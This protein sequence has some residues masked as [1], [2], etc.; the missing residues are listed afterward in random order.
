[1]QSKYRFGVGILF[2][3]IKYSRPD[4]ANVVRELSKCINGA[5]LAAYKEMHRVIKF[6]LD[7]QLNGL[8]PQPRHESEN[9][10][11]A[12]TASVIGQEILNPG[13]V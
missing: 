9:G 7:T 3:L 6:V 10:I 5:S 2:H 13:S 12:Q 1:M 11:W 8:K 4:L